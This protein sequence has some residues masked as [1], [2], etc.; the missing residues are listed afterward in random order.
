[1]LSLPPLAAETVVHIGSFPVTN[2]IINAIIAT[3]LFAIFAFFLNRGMKK[4]YVNQSHPSLALPSRGEGIKQDVAPK[5]LVNFFE[6]ILEIF[7]NQID[8][9]TKD[10]KKTL[11]FLPIVGSLFLF[12]L[13]SNWMGL[14]PGTGSLGIHHG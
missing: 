14:I 3:A 7:L 4:Y 8:S 9:V 12:I 6:S 1:M 2:T 10:R 5:G 11:K 13:V